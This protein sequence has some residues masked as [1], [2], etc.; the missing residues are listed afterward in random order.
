[1][2]TI[3]TIL[4]PASFVIML[5]VERAFPGRPLPKVRFWVL[6]GLLFFTFTG[7]VNAIVPAVLATVLDGRTL[8]DLRSLGT[9]PGAIVGFLFADLIGYWVH[10]TTHTVPFLWR[11]THQMHHSAERMDLAGMSYS[12]PLDTLVTFSLA[13]LAT[14]ILGLTPEAAALGGFFGYATAVF[15]HMN[16]Q[17]PAWLGNFIMRP[18]Q[19]GLHHERDVHAYNYANFPGWDMLFGTFRNP[20][21]FPER[22]GFWDGAS[23]KLGSMLI[24]RD[25]GTPAAPAAG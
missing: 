5:L 22:Y 16:V 14:A 6:K 9:V 19:H 11:W 13:G 1:M 3:L 17:T 23:A 21:S 4:I 25:V 24:G 8:L 18:E 10:R 20:A 2:E 12:H 7:A 15:L